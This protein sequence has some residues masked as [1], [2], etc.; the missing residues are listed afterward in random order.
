[1]FC[2]QQTNLT[3][4]LTFRVTNLLRINHPLLGLSPGLSWRLL[5]KFWATN[6]LLWSQLLLPEYEHIIW[7]ITAFSLSLLLFFAV[8][9]QGFKV[10]YANNS[11][12]CECV[13][14]IVSAGQ[15]VTAQRLH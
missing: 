9:S 11:C 8:K 5:L 6:Q 12:E 15:Q 2:C 1:M 3:V 14:A 10:M 4:Q 7:H 13:S